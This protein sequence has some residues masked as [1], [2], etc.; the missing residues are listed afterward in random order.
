MSLLSALTL[1]VLC[2]GILVFF[3]FLCC[4]SLFSLTL[5]AFF[6]I[7]FSELTAPFLSLL[8][9]A[10]LAYLPTALFIA[11]RPPFSFQQAQY[12]QDFPLKPMPF[13]TLFADLGSTNKS[14]ISPLL[15]DSHSVLATLSSPPSFL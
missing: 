8:A 7:W 4:C 9:K 10:A 6:I 13:C 11:L 1:T 12:A 5:N 3:S 2:R 14:A 15:S